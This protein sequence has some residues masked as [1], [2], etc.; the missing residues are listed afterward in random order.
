M[1]TPKEQG[2]TPPCF[3][4]ISELLD[5]INEPEAPRLK[6]KRDKHHSRRTTLLKRKTLTI[7]HA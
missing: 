7:K 2:T 4:P 6:L 5:P 1:L 3:E